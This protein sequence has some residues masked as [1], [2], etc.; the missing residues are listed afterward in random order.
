MV[1]YSIL[2]ADQTSSKQTTDED[3]RQTNRL[4]QKIILYSTNRR[5]IFWKLHYN[6]QYQIP[7][8]T[9]ILLTKE[10]T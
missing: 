8:A 7:S 10:D 1:L 3:Y 9:S 6:T 4:H 5:N 2:L